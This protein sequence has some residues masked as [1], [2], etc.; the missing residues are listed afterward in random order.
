MVCATMNA[1]L[2][3]MKTSLTNSK[4][5]SIIVSNKTLL[6]K[7]GPYALQ[8]NFLHHPTTSFYF[9]LLFFLLCSPQSDLAHLQFFPQRYPCYFLCNSSG[10][11]YTDSSLVLTAS[12]LLCPDFSWYDFKLPH[13][14]PCLQ[15]R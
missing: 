10:T 12:F 13:P 9:M 7:S 11:V 6:A 5:M 3:F 15:R 14:T 2:S 8:V 4:Q 1:A